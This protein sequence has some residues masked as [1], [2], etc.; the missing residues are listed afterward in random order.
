MVKVSKRISK[1]SSAID[2]NKVYSLEDAIKL[3]KSNSSVKF[4][5]ALDVAVKLGINPQHSD[6]IVRGVVTLPNGTGKNVRVAV[7]ARGDKANEAKESGADIV[8]SDDLVEKIDNRM[9]Q[10]TNAMRGVDKRM[11]YNLR[12]IGSVMAE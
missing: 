9:I 11:S 5:E 10:F 12:L 1:L 3:L 6:Q 4:N 7:F 2:V 8:G